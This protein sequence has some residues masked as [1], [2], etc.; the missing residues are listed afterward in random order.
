MATGSAE[1]ELPALEA[2]NATVLRLRRA[3]AVLAVLIAIPS[4]G[5]RIY[6]E[7]QSRLATLEAGAAELGEHFSRSAGT[8][9]DGW[10][11]QR[12][13]LLETLQ[14]H[15]RRGV[16]GGARLLDV[17]GN[18]VAEAGRWTDSL[19][20]TREAVVYDSGVPAGRVELQAPIAPILVYGA[21]M[22]ALGLAL[23]LALWWLVGVALRSLTATMAAL[24][25]AQIAAEVAGRARTT[26]LATMSHEIRTP[27]NG[28][29]GMT[30]LLLET[31]LD[32]VQRQ[33]INVV[34]N[35]GDALLTVINDI[36]EFSKVESGVILLEPQAFDP[37]RVVEDVLGLLAPAANGKSLELACVRGAGVPPWVLADPTRLHQILVNLVGNALKFT[38]A[39]TVVVR[40]DWPASGRLRYTISDTG[41]GLSE[42]Q[43]GHI[44]DPFVQADASTTRRFGGTGLGLAIS[45]Q[46]ALAMAGDIAVRST[47]GQGSDFTIE[48][49]ATVAERPAEL[50]EAMLVDSLA[51]QRVLLVD[52]TPVNLEIVTTLANNWG[53]RPTAVAG[54]EAALAAFGDGSLFD[55]ALLDFNMPV[56]DGVELARRLRSIKPDLRMVLLSSSAGQAA[57]GLFQARVSKPLRRMLLLDTLLNVVS[58][59]VGPPSDSA[60]VVTDWHDAEA[61]RLSSVRVL[62]VEDNPV[63]AMVARTLLERLGYLSDHAASGLEALQAV[64]RQDYDLIFMDLRM[65][66]IDGLEATRRLRELD[67]EP[68]PYV[69]G[70]TAN[71]MPDD[72]AACFA[73]GMDAYLAKPVR[74]QDL[75]AC[76]ENFARSLATELV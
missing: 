57:P 64:Q 9:P 29:I 52:D 61:G 74:L 41:V 71:V 18:A 67:L 55:L 53:M 35:S 7:A 12:N 22:A 63:N 42:E 37:E 76:L 51:G 62:V 16:A 20:L 34:R 40:I 66:D 1:T 15:V 70:L 33:Y 8:N 50:P 30:S 21:S 48:I 59:P 17:R 38:A 32:P 45:R 39:G 11:Y 75:E 25:D 31:R 49:A 54:P 10:I 23:G 56:M 69:V 28:V 19:V 68:R 36:L 72:R 4:P 60:G 24:H 58:E 5:A 27:M 43:I 2:G 13:A 46:L 14:A 73:A 65:P 26:F 47:P 6:F 3:A 44:F